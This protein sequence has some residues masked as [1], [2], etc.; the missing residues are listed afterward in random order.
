VE[1]V[2]YPIYYRACLRQTPSHILVKVV[3]ALRR[4]LRGAKLEDLG[5]LVSPPTQ[6]D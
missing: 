3:D 6:Q 4:F 5:A 1:Y 2:D